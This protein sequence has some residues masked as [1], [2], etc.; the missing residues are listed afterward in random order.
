MEIA[1]NDSVV[2]D[3]ALISWPD[4]KPYTPYIAE[5]KEIIKRQNHKWQLLAAGSLGSALAQNAYKFF[6]PDKDA[7]SDTDGPTPFI[8]DTISTWE[9]YHEYLQFKSH[10]NVT[11]VDTMALIDIAQHN[12][13]KIVE[14]EQ[15][16]KPITLGLSIT[17]SLNDRW[18]VE[19]GLQ[20][21]LLKSKFTLGEGAYYV[22]RRQ[23]VHYLGLPLR[24][25]YKWLNRKNWAVYSSVGV[26]LNLPLYGKNTERYVTDETVAYQESWHFT[27]STQ[28]SVGASIGLQYR[29]A[30]H[31]GLYLEPTFNWFVPNGSSIHT[32]WTEHPFTI[33]VPFG[34]R[35]TW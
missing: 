10:G 19:T 33:T 14:R 24:V 5:T 25:S 26:V 29:F 16:D 17:K 31:W 28:W 7:S 3:T 13:G 22:Q 34:L 20:Y 30:P 9:D 11:A 32:I 27:P 12:S 18:S 21:S 35:F 6:K 15:H 2:A 4:L 1:T 8:P 23:Q